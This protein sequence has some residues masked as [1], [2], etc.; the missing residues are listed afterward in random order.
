ME[1]YVIVSNTELKPGNSFALLLH[2][3]KRTHTQNLGM[4]LYYV[5]VRANAY[6]SEA[7]R[8]KKE[9]KEKAV[10]RRVHYT[11]TFACDT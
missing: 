5:N 10:N 1:I 3:P 8:E 2:W 9:E 6:R 7:R 4:N 11:R